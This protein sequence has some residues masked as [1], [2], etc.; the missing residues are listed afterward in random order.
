MIC[1]DLQMKAIQRPV[2]YHST[3]NVPNRFVGTRM[4]HK[5]HAEGWLAASERWSNTAGVKRTG[6][7]DPCPGRSAFRA[8]EV[9]SMSCA[10][11]LSR[12]R[13]GR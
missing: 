2:Q 13:P 11:F 1:S 10:M 8:F 7:P 3:E 12:H 9:S 6:L 5:P 4:L